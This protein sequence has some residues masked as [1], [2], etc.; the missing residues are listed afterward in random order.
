MKIRILTQSF[1]NYNYDNYPDSPI[2]K[3][4]GSQEFFVDVN[5]D[6]DCVLYE[7]DLCIAVIKSLIAEKES[8]L[9]KYEYLS[10]EIVFS[11]PIKLTG[12]EMRLNTFRFLQKSSQK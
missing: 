1:E 7:E 9:I 3:A 6:D 11:E 12:F 5:D 8:A 10:F 2:W 4:K